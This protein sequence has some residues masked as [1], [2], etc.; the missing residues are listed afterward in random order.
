MGVLGPRANLSA[1]GN[2]LAVVGQRKLSEPANFLSF[3]AKR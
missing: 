3:H 2:N 1:I